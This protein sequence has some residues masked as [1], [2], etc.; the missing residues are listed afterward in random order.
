MASTDHFSRFAATYASY[1]P[2]YPPELFAWLAEQAPSR[3]HAWDCATGTGQAAVALA[4]HFEHVTATDVGQ[5]MIAQA[6]PHPNIR[7]AVG[8]AE[9][10]PVESHSADLVTV[11]QALHWFDRPAFWKTCERV[12]RP[13]GLLAFWGYVLPNIVPAVNRLV[14]DYHDRIILNFWPPGR[15]PLL[16]GYQDVTVPPPARYEAHPEFNMT[17]DW[18]V[19]QLIGMLESWSATQRARAETGEDPLADLAPK[20]RRAW[21]GFERRRVEWPLFLQVHRY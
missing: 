2:T 13:G 16:A 15:E 18:T 8:P 4:E 14:D 7:Y 17:A 1:R 10:P 21:G 6:M 19:E 3:K 11:A 12:L 5:G 9:S 20:L